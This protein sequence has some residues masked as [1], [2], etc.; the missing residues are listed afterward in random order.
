[1]RSYFYESPD[2]FE[3]LFEILKNTSMNVKFLAGGSDFVPRLSLE[4]EQIP[5]ENQNDLLIIN[6]SD[7]KLN[8]I[9]ES[10][11]EITIG[12]TATLSDIIKNDIIKREFPVLAETIKEIAGFSVRSIATIGGNIMNA[13][14]AADSV[15]VL[16]VLDAEFVLKGPKGLKRV[17]SKDFFTGPGK[18]IAKENEV[19]TEVVIK[20]QKGNSSFEKLGRRKAETL[21]IVN[22]AVYIEKENNICKVARIAVGSV[23]PTVLRCTDIE[24][25]LE[26]K[27]LTDENIK[28][29][30][31][32]VVEAICPIDDI[33]ASAWYR[34]KVAPVIVRRAIEAAISVE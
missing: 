16:M 19:L 31:E 15:P 3:K 13:S 18:T 12:A 4:R 29:A 32:K 30:V 5:K 1:M 24:Q 10:D 21:S 26:G 6:L 20:K 7:L 17:N 27:E 8:L 23:A 22:A 2:S 9:T 25:Y 28:H 34:N 33:R 11:D 14:P